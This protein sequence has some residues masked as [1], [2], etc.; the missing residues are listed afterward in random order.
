M[1]SYTLRLVLLCVKSASVTIA[2]PRKPRTN[3]KRV[4]DVTSASVTIA[5]LRKPRANCKPVTDVTWR[6]DVQIRLLPEMSSAY[7][8]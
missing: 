7:V 5:N 2:N 4:T 3:C 1:A 8:F 6:A